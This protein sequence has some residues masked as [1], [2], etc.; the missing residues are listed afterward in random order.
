[1]TAVAD[2]RT[3]LNAGFTSVR[4]LG[5]DPRGIRALR[6]AMDTGAVE[7]RASPRRAT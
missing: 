6:D 5:G 4:D 2:A 7:G 3:T 1:M